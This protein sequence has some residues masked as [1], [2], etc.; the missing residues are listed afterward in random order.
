M[1]EKTTIRRHLTAWREAQSAEGLAALSDELCRQAEVLPEYRRATWVLGYAPFRREPDIR[2]L[3]ERALAAGKRV[4]MPR[5]VTAD[6]TLGFYEIRSWAELE[7]GSYGIAEPPA[8]EERRWQ[9]TADA[10]CFV[11]ALGY[12]NDGYRLGYGGGYY[13]RFLPTFAGVSVGLCP[14]ECLTKLPREINDRPVTAV[15]TERGRIR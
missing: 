8:E 2:P 14:S 1:T 11:P 12:D 9:P 7:T 15:V 4:A 6:H 10:V 3:I 5:C 13:D